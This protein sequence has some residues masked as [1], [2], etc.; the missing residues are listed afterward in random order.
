MKSD[1]LKKRYLRYNLATRG[2]RYEDGFRYVR[3]IPEDYGILFPWSGG[4]VMNKCYQPLSAAFLDRTGRI[5]EI[6]DME[7]EPYS[8][9]P[10][11]VYRCF[12][13]PYSFVLEAPLGWFQRAG[14][15]PGCRLDWDEKFI[16]I[17]DTP[18][19]EIETPGKQFSV[20]S[21]PSKGLDHEIWDL[22]SG[23][24][25]PDLRPEVQREILSRLFR[26]LSYAGFENAEKWIPRAFLTGSSTTNQF[27]K[28]SD[29][30]VNIFVDVDSMKKEVT[31]DDIKDLTNEQVINKLRSIISERVS[32]KPLF[33]TEHRVNYYV[34]YGDTDMDSFDSVYDIMNGEWVK[35]PF[36]APKDFD[37]E[38]AFPDVYQ[39]A[40]ALAKEFD[41]ILGDIRRGSAKAAHLIEKLR[42]INPRDREIIKDKL[43]TMITVLDSDIKK[44]IDKYD[45]VVKDRSS[46]FS[47]DSDVVREGYLRSKNWLPENLKYK[48]LEKWRYLKL[49]RE[50]YKI[51]FSRD[52]PLSKKVRKI[53]KKFCLSKN[54]VATQ[55]G[56]VDNPFNTQ[57]WSDIPSSHLGYEARFYS[58]L[59]DLRPSLVQLAVRASGND[60]ETVINNV[61]K[62]LT[63]NIDKIKAS[64]DKLKIVDFGVGDNNEVYVVLSSDLAGDYRLGIPLTD[65]PAHGRSSIDEH[66]IRIEKI[67][68][69]DRDKFNP[70]LLMLS[71]V[72]FMPASVYNLIKSCAPYDRSSLMAFYGGAIYPYLLASQKN[73][74]KK[75]STMIWDNAF[76]AKKVEADRVVVIGEK[77]Q[78]ESSNIL[79]KRGY[80][81]V[82]AD[83]GRVDGLKA[84]FYSRNGLCKSAQV[85]ESK[86]E[87]LKFLS[88]AMNACCIIEI[89]AQGN[90]WTGSGFRISDRFVVS[91]AHVITEGLR[92]P[93]I[94]KLD[95]LTLSFNRSKK[96]SAGVYAINPD[97]DLVVLSLDS[98]GEVPFKEVLPI[99][100]SSRLT[101]GFPV[102]AIGSPEG[103]EAILSKGIVS[104]TYRNVED[105]PG[106]DIFFLNIEIH[107]GSSGGPVLSYDL[108]GVVGVARGSLGSSVENDW[109]NYCIA[110]STLMK[111]LDSEKIPY[112]RG[113]SQSTTPP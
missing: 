18:F 68:R 111:W 55:M 83:W 24:D 107:P 84:F 110:S 72:E 25:E 80:S 21:L 27:D 3:K 94:S 98:P 70:S 5:I 46:A 99:A 7:P 45:K 87:A 93:S 90:M 61:V 112:I 42:K 56:F 100:D 26:E 34:S 86:L 65:I 36:F 30:D 59:K 31:N 85:D 48:W 73:G 96:I 91:C 10:Q 28:D 95:R 76:N 74:S 60:A 50:L 113:G 79:E 77:L 14:W 12:S 89:S 62:F 71:S 97:A 32:G 20:I 92:D 9:T 37:P 43:Q 75:T 4:M 22:E 104:S 57:N 69:F 105:L 29:I 108:G 39:D 58:Y 82:A 66:G 49:A 51:W 17:K 35:P 44:L 54:S 47:D 16:F 101:P 103:I 109:V 52:I 64:N 78:P 81:L 2:S 13:E 23:K 88:S 38:S 1:G 41:I 106:A 67:P 63:E 19:D 33:T 102:Y 6:K 15:E 53:Q 8:K 40:V 11:K